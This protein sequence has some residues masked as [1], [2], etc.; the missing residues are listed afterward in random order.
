M[1]NQ[2]DRFYDELYIKRWSNKSMSLIFASIPS[3]MMWDDHDIF[4]GWGSY[5]EDIQK[6]DVYKN[7]FS[8]A[9]KYFENFQIR[10]IHNMESHKSRGRTLLHG[11]QIS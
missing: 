1:K 7:I 11:I 8:V 2:I 4:D 10:T 9:K 6:C 3:V 5:P